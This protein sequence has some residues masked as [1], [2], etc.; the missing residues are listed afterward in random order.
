[1]F[2]DIINELDIKN[3]IHL[4]LTNLKKDNEDKEKDLLA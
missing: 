3:K 1:M 4:R 2:T